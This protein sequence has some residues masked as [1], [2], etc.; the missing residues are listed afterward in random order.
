M[1]DGNEESAEESEGDQGES[2][3]EPTTLP[4]LGGGDSADCEY[5]GEM[6]IKEWIQSA[7]GLVVGEIQEIEPA[8]ELGYDSQNDFELKTVEECPGE[9]DYAFRVTLGDLEGYLHDKDDLPDTLD[10]YFGYFYLQYFHWD[11]R[12]E[13]TPEG[14]EWPDDDYEMVEGMR[15]GG[16][17]F[18][19]KDLERWSFLRVQRPMFQVIEGALAFQGGMR[20]EPCG[21]GPPTE[22]IEDLGYPGLISEINDWESEG[23]LFTEPEE[24]GHADDTQFLSSYVGLCLPEDWGEDGGD[25]E[26]ECQTSRD[27]PE[28]QTCSLGEC[29]GP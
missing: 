19:N 25:E 27:C 3:G 10:V 1:P 12:P 5:L 8:L 11:M 20:D 6:S 17:L 18:E 4:P 26:Y 24:R 15:I 23:E 13:I 21:Y 29:T 22:D 9:I 7:D 14:I 16:S 28:D 2:E